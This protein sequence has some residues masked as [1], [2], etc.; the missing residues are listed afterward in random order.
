[1]PSIYTTPVLMGLLAIGS[2]AQESPV[3]LCNGKSCKYCPSSLTT[4]GTGYPS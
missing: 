1:M 2:V 3:K 4:T